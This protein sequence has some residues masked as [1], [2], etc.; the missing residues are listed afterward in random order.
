MKK[1][2][3][4]IKLMPDFTKCMS[5]AIFLTFS[6]NSNANNSELTYAEQTNFTI[7]MENQT[8]K[9]VVEWIEKNSQFIFIYDTDLDLSHRVNVDVHNKPV[10]EILKQIFSGTNL[11]YNI[12]NRQVMIR[13]AEVKTVRVNQVVQQE[14]V[15]IKGIVTDIKGE[16]IIGANI[17]EDGT[18]NGTITDIDGQF[19]LQVDKGAKLIISYI[20]YIT[21]T[22]PVGQNHFL[23]VSLREDNKT[24]EEVVITGYG[25][26]QLRSKMTNSIAKVDN[27]VLANG[28]YT[29][30]AQALSGAV[31]GLRVQQTSGKPNATPT[32]V[33]RGG[34]NLDGSGSPLIIIDGAVRES[35]SDV[36]PEDIESME[37]MK[38]AG[39]TAIYG[40]RASNGVV[41]VT[42]KKGTAGRT[43]V[44]LSAKVGLNFFHS[45]YEFLDAHDYLYYMRSAFHRSSHIWQ[46]QSG[47]WRGF[48]S[49]AT[50]SGTQ[51]YGTGN[52]YFDANGNVLNGN[53]DNTAVW[54]VMNYTDD[55][56]FLL[57]QG[58]QTMD[59]P[60]NPGQKLIYAD[61]QLKDYNIKSPAISQD[62]NLSVSGGNDK[63]HYYAS[64]GY[65]HSEGNAVNNWYRRLNFTIN[66]DYKIKPWLTSNSSLS[67]TDSKWD[68]GAA[69]YAG[70]TNFFSTTLSVPPTFRVKSPDG[71]WLAGPA[72]ASYA[73]GWTTAKV[74]E[75]ALNYDNNTD[76][77]NMSQSF[78]FNIMKG[79]T[80]KATGAW[81]YFDDS[82]EFFKGDYIV[83]TGPVYDTNHS[84]SNKHE[85]LLDQTYNGILNYQTTFLQ[86]HT[87]DAMLGVEYY[88]S[89]KKGFSASGY[90]SPLSDF[91]DLN[92]TSTASGV[93]QIDSWHYRQRILSFFGRVNY[94]YKS[95]Y[96]LSL[97]LRRDGYSKLPKDNRWG[98]FPGISGGWVFSKESFMEDMADVLSYAKVRASY[99]ANGNVSGVLDAN[100]NIV[101]G[102]DYYTV[103]GSYGIMKDKN[104]K[105]VANYNGKVPLMLNDLPNPTMRWEKSYTFET[106]LDLGFLNNKYVLNFTYYNRH[107]QDKFAE[108]T[109]PS[110]SGVSSFLSNNGE[111]QNQ[112][113]ELELTANILRTK[114]WRFTV[115]MNT[116]YNKNKIVSLPYNG[117]PNNMQDAYQVYTGNKLSD[118]SYEKKWVGGYQEGQEYGVIYGFKSL[119][120]YKSES[121]IAGNLIDRSTYTENGADAK[122]LYGPDA[123]AKMSDAEK[124]KGLPIQ[125]GDVKWL[126]VNDDG[127]IDDYDRVKLGN[128]IP[129]WTGGFNIN[130]SWKGLSLNCRLDSALGF[131]V[132]DFKTPWIMGNMQGTFNTISLVKDSWSE[133]NPNGKYPVYGWADFLGKRNYDRISDINCYRGDY[134]AFREVSMAYTLPQNWI[135]KTG[136]S[137]VNVSVTAQNLGYI[138]AAK[139]MATPEYGVSQNG[140]YPI[141]RSVVFGLNVTF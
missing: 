33:L 13:K 69:G 108:I 72:V 71:D 29:N 63:G 122:V 6:G 113:M 27:S 55:L 68:D 112:G 34:T 90:G 87:L 96:L 73:R 15:T 17:I 78:T 103:Q 121:E 128:T 56:A 65:N 125:A 119:G 81:Y 140:G 95:K 129:H 66:A 116:A 89:Y 52:R 94:D 85:R 44:N 74:Y 4:R 76:K 5:L 110:H 54:G 21:Q 82:R 123:W 80:F 35:L 115:S 114:D 2:I 36:N 132:P 75:D 3:N 141:P 43:E 58:W 42:T 39:A 109:L 139:N 99:G 136:L 77:F 53:K 118:G 83:A 31:A 124:E 7:S 98:T 93:R 79:L 23:K 133:T 60:V 48:A 92:Y 20:G 117:L 49:D 107:T 61:N 14:K 10:E 19:S 11:E 64:L 24:L 18:T 8:L 47:N 59:D 51:P 101:T 28:T 91:Q 105:T 130:T 84:T 104:G 46:D 50:L 135:L 86:D 137:K 70:E 45:Q 127:V 120:I 67:F 134:L 111:V 25:G 62:Y 38:D 88:D 40:A 26:T 131:W 41:L 57:K 32:L 126:D 22:L 106:G 100:G 30:P 12:R 138:T 97:V 102:L 37:V 1:N 9:S 16:A